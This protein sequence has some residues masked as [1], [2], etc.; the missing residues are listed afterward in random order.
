MHVYIHIV[1]VVIQTQCS[2]F[3]QDSGNC[4]FVSNGS[5]CLVGRTRLVIHTTIVLI[6]LLIRCLKPVFN[7]DAMYEALG[8]SE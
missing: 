2:L 5:R 7:R 1:I 3:H 8:V 6:N 4:M